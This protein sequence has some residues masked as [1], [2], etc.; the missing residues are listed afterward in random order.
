MDSYLL[1][2][3]LHIVGVVLF[4]G[5]I[6]VTAWWKVMADRT[7]DPKIIA[8][9]QRQVTLTDWV[10]TFGGIVL[11]AIGG[12]GNAALHGI[13]MTLAWLAWG[14]ALFILSGVIWVAVLIPVQTKLA[15]IARTF[16]D[17]GTI[18]ETYWRLEK[19]WGLFGGIATVLP[20]ANIAIMV[21]KPG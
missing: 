8:F 11:V 14:N 10:F 12:Y 3:T 21:F 17:G 6:I 19:L 15:R 1:L 7:R 4:I 2:K 9:A 16:A 20:L 13:P 5:N 18:P